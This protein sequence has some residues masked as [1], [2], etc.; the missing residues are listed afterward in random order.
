MDVDGDNAVNMGALASAQIAE[1]QFNEALTSCDH[2]LKQDPTDRRVL[3]D[4]SIALSFLG[5]KESAAHI[6]DHQHLLSVSSIDVPAG[7]DSITEFNQAIIAHAEQHPKIRY[8]GLNHTCL[9]GTTSNEIFVE[10]LGPVGELQRIITA[11]AQA[12][13]ETLPVNESHL[14]LSH[15]PDQS[16]LSMSGWV[17]RLRTQG[18]QQGHI[19]PTAWIS[20][21]YYMQLPPVD[22]SAPE[23]GG[24]EFGRSPSYYPDGGDQGDTRLIRPTEGTLV[25]FP[26]YFY[27]R[28]IPFDGSD[29][30]I[31][32]AFD[33]RT[34]EFHEG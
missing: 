33:F 26:S 19:H 3:A 6:F 14:W 16:L 18:Y 21:V 15:L 29:Q 31:T 4:K 13:R 11:A 23:A 27:H 32:L 5:K 12:Y 7:Y 2:S 17:T 28:T 10:P 8:D 24:I 1:K 9:G 25:L 34:A 22:E 20:G 30:R